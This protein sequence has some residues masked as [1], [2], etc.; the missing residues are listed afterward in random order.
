MNKFLNKV[1]NDRKINI[2]TIL[3]LIFFSIAAIFPIGAMHS[4][5]SIENTAEYL[6]DVAKNHSTSGTY[7]AMMI[8]PNNT[9]DKKIKDPYNEF[10]DLYGI[11]REKIATYV[12]TANAEKSHTIKLKEIDEDINFSFLNVDRGFGVEKYYEDDQ[13]NVVYRQAFYP[14]ELM[15][16]SEHK[17]ISDSYSFFYISQT[18]ADSILEKRGLPHASLQDYS[19]L[20]NKLTIVE[21]D[22]KEYKFAIDN[23]YY[24]RNYFYDALTE[25]MGEFFLG[26]QK[27]P[28]EIKRQGLFFL[29]NFAYQNKF[30]IDY[31]T[32]E[33]SEK[34]FN[35][36]ILKYNLQDNFEINQDKIVFFPST[37]S[38]ITAVFLLVIAIAILSC[39]VFLMFRSVFEFK[40]INII[41]CCIAL[42]APYL[43]FW[44]IYLFSKNVFLFS[45]FSTASV[46]WSSLGFIAVCFIA[47]LFKI[48]RKEKPQQ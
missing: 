6:A 36:H 39:S 17:A 26:G 18:R 8:E 4:S 44:I 1:L 38:D 21:I 42:F 20:L 2:I 14:L 19:V 33:Y 40:V 10:V 28:Q 41:F 12:G 29:R 32:T 13:G 11:F 22:G 23:I 46:M 31:A 3:F 47:F 25:V 30:Y 27:Y 35:F 15:F 43:L 34:D 48:A 45:A 16:Y 5:S 37:S 7:A 24:E 9:T